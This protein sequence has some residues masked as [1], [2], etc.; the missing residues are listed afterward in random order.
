M[1]SRR[2]SSQS[3]AS[4]DSSFS[5]HNNNENA[6]NSTTNTNEANKTEKNVDII[7]LSKSTDNDETENVNNQQNNSAV[8]QLE[9]QVYKPECHTEN[10]KQ[11]DVDQALKDDSN[12]K[13][14]PILIGKNVE[15]LPQYAY[16]NP[17][18]YQINLPLNDY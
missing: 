14:K 10:E 15:K 5:L 2:D 6:A 4:G 18:F 8:I 3:S 7:D 16:E 13:R 11:P 1:S 12:T 9:S 17:Q